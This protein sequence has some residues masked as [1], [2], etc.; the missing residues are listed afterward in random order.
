MKTLMY[1]VILLFKFHFPTTS[2]IMPTNCS[3][4]LNPTAIS[5]HSIL[6]SYCMWHYLLV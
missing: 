2:A 6:E 1:F 3:F 4:H 5:K